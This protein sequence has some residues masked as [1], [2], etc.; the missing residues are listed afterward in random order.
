MD[1]GLATCSVPFQ[2]VAAPRSLARGWIGVSN[3]WG[4]A[5]AL[6]VTVARVEFRGIVGN[7]SA[8]LD[9]LSRDETELFV[10]RELVPVL[11]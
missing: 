9:L 6:R 4:C 7:G 8:T 5:H 3:S 10:D 1:R 11:A 2:P